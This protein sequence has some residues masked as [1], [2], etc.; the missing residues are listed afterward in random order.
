MS[1]GLAAATRILPCQQVTIQQH[2]AQVSRPITKV[3]LNHAS[4]SVLS[5]LSRPVPA[6]V[7]SRTTPQRRCVGPPGAA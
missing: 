3:P 4:V 5:V 2:A 1:D 7:P 6:P